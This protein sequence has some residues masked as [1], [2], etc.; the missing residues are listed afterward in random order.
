MSKKT[1]A[2]AIRFQYHGMM[3]AENA[4]KIHSLTLME[5]VVTVSMSDKNMMNLKMSARIS[6]G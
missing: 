5:Q 6:V 4:L 2:F 3:V 1:N